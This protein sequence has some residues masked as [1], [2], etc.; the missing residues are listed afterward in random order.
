MEKTKICGCNLPTFL[1]IINF[2]VGLMM[3]I[4]GFLNFLG[5]LKGSVS[6]IIV[7]LAFF[8]F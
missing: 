6:A 5:F 3:V 1:K 7:N 4:F 2:I 8:F